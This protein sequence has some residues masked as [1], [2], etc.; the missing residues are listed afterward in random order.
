MAQTT[1]NYLYRLL[2]GENIKDP[3][4]S[5][6]DLALEQLSPLKDFSFNGEKYNI[7]LNGVKFMRKI[8]EPG[9][10]EAEVSIERAP[11]TTN[12]SVIPTQA[13]I[14]E[15][16]MKRRVALLLIDKNQSTTTMDYELDDDCIAKNFFVYMVNPQIVKNNGKP[17]MF[18]KLTIY[19]MDK[20]MTLD[21][22]S[23]VYVAKK[24]GSGILDM[25]SRSFGF[26][27]LMFKTNTESLQNL[28]YKQSSVMKDFEGNSITVNIGS[29]F[30][31]PYLVQYNES[32]YDFMV[33]TSNRCGEF[34][35][36]E[37]GQLFMGLPETVDIPT[38]SA[39]S[40]VTFQN[41]S[42]SP[43]EVNTFSRDSVKEGNGSVED[44]NIEVIEKD[45]AG[46]PKD[47]FP[48]Q[49]S[50]NAELANDEYIYPLYKDK[51]TTILH[52]TSFE[53]WS[54]LPIPVI[55]SMM[56]AEFKNIKTNGIANA[57]D[58]G[59]ALATEY[60]KLAAFS[61]MAH[62]SVNSEGNATFLDPMKSKSEQ[63]SD[64]CSVYFSGLKEDGWTSLNYYSDVRQY[65]EQQQK[66]I[67]CIDMGT[68]YAPV[69]LGE[70]IKVE[71]LSDTY[72]VIQIRQVSNQMWTRNYKVFDP[73]DTST[74]KYTNKQSQ[75]IYA[76]PT[77]Q[78]KNDNEKAIPPVM[79]VSIVRKAG[80]QTAFVVDNKDP[81]RQGRVRIAYPWQSANEGKR[82]EL[83]AAEQ[84]LYLAEESVKASEIRIADLRQ[85]IKNLNAQ[86]GELE[87][88]KSLSEDERKAK[89]AEFDTEIADLK[90]KIKALE[91]PEVTKTISAGE[92]AQRL[93]RQA[94]KKRLEN[95]LKVL[96]ALKKVL[97]GNSK[98]DI[99]TIIKD[100]EAEATKITNETLPQAKKDVA[101]A[102]D[103]KDKKAE[104][105]NQKADEWNGDLKSMSSPW[106]RVATPMATQ[107]GGTYFKP[108]VGD[109]VLVNYDNDNIERPYVVGSLFSK[110]VPDPDTFLNITRTES[111]LL[112]DATT[113]IM[114][115]N[116]HHISFKDMPD[117]KP[118]FS[119]IQGGLGALAGIADLSCL[120][121]ATGGIHIGDRYG[122]YEL[123]M[124]SH[125][126][127]IKISSPMGDV[128]IDAY[129]GITIMSP[130]GD[131]KIVGK[132]VSIEAG[133]NLELTSG[134]NIQY[135]VEGHPKIRYKIANGIKGAATSIASNVLQSKVFC[136]VDLS[137]VRVVVETFLRPIEG[138]ACIKSRR[139]LMLEG[140]KGKAHIAQDRY[141]AKEKDSMK[142]EQNFFNNLMDCVEHIDNKCSAFSENY[143]RLY[144]IAHEHYKLFELLVETL[145]KDDCDKKKDMV[146]TA[147]MR[148]YQAATRKSQDKKEKWKNPMEKSEY[149]GKVIPGTVAIKGGLMLRADK[150]KVDKLTSQANK[151]A[152]AAYNVL[153]YTEEFSKILLEKVHNP[154]VEPMDSLLVKAFTDTKKVR[155]EDWK[156]KYFKNYPKPTDLFLKNKA[157]DTEG[158]PFVAKMIPYKRY[159]IAYFIGLVANDDAYALP[160]AEGFGD[161]LSNLVNDPMAALGKPKGKYL[162]IQYEVKNLKEDRMES[163]YHWQQFVAKMRKFESGWSRFFFDSTAGAL[164]TALQLNQP[165]TNHTDK[166]YKNIWQQINDRDAWA[167]RKDGLILL[168]DRK[169]TTF[170]FDSGT[171]SSSRAENRGNWDYLTE[172][173]LRGLK[174]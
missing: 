22:Y 19:S 68:T 93:A 91:L 76:I 158:D 84:Q 117:G 113:T 46:Y 73:S 108:Q 67:I 30:I 163:A 56:K 57:I 102:K 105:L 23:K 121:D 147:I 133:N 110:N 126:R 101:S 79:P 115:P 18:V 63:Y 131:V 139:Y 124:S 154:A 44:L 74:D 45:K 116:G 41:F 148:A 65:E 174:K 149:E 51:W 60:G 7:N 143:K 132:N 13:V 135:P 40:S 172:Y 104:A 6:D 38:I 70:K 103:T 122:L 86:V 150:E 28:R 89:L 166:H 162:R 39:Y 141:G 83:Q 100:M 72:V 88:M 92:Y 136:Y 78:D 59:V 97:S 152:K 42:E 66:K 95:R 169:D 81:K 87:K 145:V 2:F 5:L 165:L 58:F 123:S 24:L 159:L 90:K 27:S 146:S 160:P 3:E 151:L 96:E 31:Q 62:F 153:L 128:N 94:E 11:T 137:F 64:D 35:F 142:E 49:V 112:K 32:F 48:K 130:N 106:V 161:K 75:V 29:E 85:S 20:L 173:L 127:K 52:E 8:Y 170:A 37:D 54:S 120:K 125:D 80:P 77:Y 61:V 118:F 55:F 164:Q 119:T 155:Y 171:W 21:K 16:F 12:P 111:D 69:K 168:S 17:S 47:T 71:G 138:T 10:I 114:S 4:N 25:E 43:I 99:D 144:N 109:E 134:T 33:R 82:L 14:D 1:N 157:E 156:K 98:A 50:Y 34:L 15:L 167:D 53:K 26:K 36:F 129:S 140:G 9:L 107:G